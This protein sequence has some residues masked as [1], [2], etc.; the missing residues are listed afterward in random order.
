MPAPARKNPTELSSGSLA[1]EEESESDN[2]E[3]GLVID[4]SKKRREMVATRLKRGRQ[5]GRTNDDED[6]NDVDT[7]NTSPEL[8][9]T[10]V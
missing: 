3:K 6:I 5:E 1:Y 2:K 10:K 4:I 9:I 7:N 8:A